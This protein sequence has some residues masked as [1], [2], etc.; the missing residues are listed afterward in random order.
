MPLCSSFSSIPGKLDS[1]NCFNALS[2]IALT[3]SPF[4]FAVS[5]TPPPNLDFRCCGLYAQ[6]LTSS[7]RLG[8][9]G[10]RDAE[11]RRIKGA[12][13]GTTTQSARPYGNAPA[14]TFEL[15]VNHYTKARAQ[16]LAL[17]HA[18]G[19]QDYCATFG[20]NFK[21]NVP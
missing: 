10:S 11:K 4:N 9:L 3:S 17:F 7:V 13:C 1:R 15:A 20:D 18:V 12:R 19:R 2:F 16:R 14:K 8:R 6:A 21:Q 5:E